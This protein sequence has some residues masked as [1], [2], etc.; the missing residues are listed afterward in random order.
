MESPT[1]FQSKM[2]HTLIF[3][4]TPAIAKYSESRSNS[5]LKLIKKGCYN[6][7]T[8][9]ETYLKNSP[10]LEAV[11]ILDSWR[12]TNIITLSQSKPRLKSTNTLKFSIRNFVSDAKNSDC[13]NHPKFNISSNLIGNGNLVTDTLQRLGIETQFLRT[14]FTRP[15]WNSF[16]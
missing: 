11:T 7:T 14:T 12:F 2:S 15:L 4:V 3:F 16:K 8:E 10:I 6:I 9:K 1:K 13:L 5:M